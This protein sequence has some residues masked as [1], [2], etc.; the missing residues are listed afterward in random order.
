M[1]QVRGYN[2]FPND[3]EQPSGYK[4]K[5]LFVPLTLPSPKQGDLCISPA[6]V[7][8]RESKTTEA[9]SSR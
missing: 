7:I 3:F 4:L 1:R 6:I 9:I 5:I 8:A 2:Q